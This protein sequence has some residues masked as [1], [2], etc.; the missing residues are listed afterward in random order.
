MEDAAGSIPASCFMTKEQKIAEQV[1]VRLMDMVAI[2]ARLAEL[3]SIC[4]RMNRQLEVIKAEAA[5][6][7][8]ERRRRCPHKQTKYWPDAS[9]NN[10]SWTE[11]LDCGGDVNQLEWQA[12]RAAYRAKGGR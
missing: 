6:L 7:Y 9:G 3:E 10:D 2:E 12:R 5:Q 1:A 4:D 8:D 11:C